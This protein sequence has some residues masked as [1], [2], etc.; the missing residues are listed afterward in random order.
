MIDIK[1]MEITEE[2]LETICWT[3]HRLSRVSNLTKDMNLWNA[4]HDLQMSQEKD[5]YRELMLLALKEADINL[6]EVK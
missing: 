4:I 2:Q 1:K 6:K 3:F 5:V